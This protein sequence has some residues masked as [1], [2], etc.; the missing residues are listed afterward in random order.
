MEGR[1]RESAEPDPAQ[2]GEPGGR[3]VSYP[4]A[5]A[6][7][8]ARFLSHGTIEMEA[9]AEDLLVSRATLYRVVGNRD[10]LLGDVLWDL[11]ER[12]L[13]RA[14]EETPPEHTGADRIVE[15][16]RR[17]N[18]QVVAFA[19]LQE[20]LRN[21]PL[22]AFRVLFSPAGHVHE[23]AVAAWRRMLEEEVERGDIVPPFD[24]DMLAYVVVRTG[25]SMLYADLI[26]G[27]EP[28]VEL[29]AIVQRAVLRADPEG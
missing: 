19:P 11:G 13:R 14:V 5:L 1:A 2:R 22:T 15:T 7:A 26:L 21:E 4:E 18:E 6:R 17:F 20:F 27:R 24:L 25:E 29:A 23:R 10:R 3:A 16:S 8:R 28:D 12:T 9:L